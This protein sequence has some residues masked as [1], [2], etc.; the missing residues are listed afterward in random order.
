MDI[1]RN[2]YWVYYC[3]PNKKIDKDKCGKWM[4]F[5]NDNKSIS[6]ICEK[7]IKL[8]IVDIAKHSND[9]KGVSC[10]YLHSDNIDGHK[11]VISFF[12]ENK[13]IKKTNTGRYHDISFKFDN[14]TRDGLYGEDFNSD[15]KLSNFINLY[16][17][18]WLL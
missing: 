3:N 5:F 15:I 9:I 10:F 8:N 14:Q 11:K 18:E 12:I 7:A 17:G 6:K 4:Y 16:T 13:L 1:Y 2:K